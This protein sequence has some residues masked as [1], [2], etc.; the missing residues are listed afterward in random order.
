MTRKLFS[1]LLVWILC[2]SLALSVSAK[3]E[4]LY[5]E[6]DLLTPAE[7]SALGQKLADISHSYNA[8]LVVMT[9]A[10]SDGRSADFLL[11]HLYDSRGFGYGENHDGVLLLVCMDLREYRILS[12]GYAGDAISSYEIDSLCGI[13]DTYLPDGHYATA[14]EE[15][16][17]QC[18]YFLD[19]YLN[20]YPFDFGTNL[21]ISIV[22][23][24][25]VGLIVALILKAQ[26]KSV[27]QQSEANVYVKSGSLKLNTQRDIFL[28]RHVTRR[29]K[30]KESSSSSR[31]SGGG[32]S[33]SRGGGSF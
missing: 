18:G 16:A 3:E 17:D 25:V 19:G 31:S 4:F 28:Y 2:F 23:G 6:A 10:S 22:I 13:M 33:R 29:E 27:H 30:P 21:L 12:N 11:D 7:E 32:S 8:Q 15:F 20:G 24:F 14:F 26:L 9:L 1:A 5:D